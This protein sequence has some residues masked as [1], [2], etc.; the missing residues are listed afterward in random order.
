MFPAPPGVSAYY[1]EELGNGKTILTDYPVV[2]FD[3]EGVPYYVSSGARDSK[4]LVRADRWTNYL[5]VGM[6]RNDPIIGVVPGQ[7]WK[8]V[9][10]FEED[11]EETIVPVVAWTIDSGGNC[12]PR[13]SPLFE[14]NAPDADTW[15]DPREDD[16]F[17]RMIAPG[18]PE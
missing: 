9:Y 8:V 11:D 3:D 4:T 6:A 7:G 15:F 16:A 13:T 1:E 12:K 10:K 18:M 5:G 14:L 2:A 17:V